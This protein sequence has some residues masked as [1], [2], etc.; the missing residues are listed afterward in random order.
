MTGVSWKTNKC[1]PSWI[2]PDEVLHR[3]LASKDE[4]H[5]LA[6][7]QQQQAASSS[8]RRSKSLCEDTE[9]QNRHLSRSKRWQSDCA[10]LAASFVPF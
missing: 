8:C 10:S 9:A 6:S 5:I 3:L 4:Q 1:L 7:K 2:Y